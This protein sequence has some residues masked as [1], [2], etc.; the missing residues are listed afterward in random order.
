MFVVPALAPGFIMR[1]NRRLA[2]TVQHAF[3]KAHALAYGEKREPWLEDEFVLPPVDGP[4]KAFS[5]KTVVK[6]LRS[7]AKR[8]VAYDVETDGRHPLL[9]D[10]R[11]VGFYD[12]KQGVT[13]P[14]LRRNGDREDRMVRDRKG[15]V[16]TEN[17]AV[18]VRYWSE[19][20]E[21]EIVEAMRELIGT[22]NK[23]RS[24][25]RV[26]TQNGQYDRMVLWNALGLRVPTGLTFD[27]IVA[28]HVICPYLPH[29]LGF[30]S[31]LYTN[32]PF[33]KS[34]DKGDSWASESDHELFLYCA[35]G[36]TRVVMADGS[37]RAIKDLVRQ[38]STEEVRVVNERGEISTSPIYAWHQVRV[39][40]QTWRLIRNEATTHRGLVLT[41]DHKVLIKNR[42]K[43]R[44]D[45]VKVGDL[46]LL[47]ERRFSLRQQSLL[48]GTLLG[49]SVL[50]VSPAFRGEP[51]KA[52]AA[53]VDGGQVHEAY[54]REKVRAL[55]GIFALGRKRRTPHQDFHPFSSRQ[56]VQLKEW[57]SVWRD[58]SGRRRIGRELLDVLAKDPAGL[59]WWF[60]DDG[61][62]QKVRQGTDTICL[63]LLRYPEEDRE[64][65]RAWFEE[66]FGRV[67][68]YQG[69]LRFSVPAT[70]RFTSV[71]GPFL[72]PSVRYKLPG[73]EELPYV[74]EPAEPTHEPVAVRV[75]SNEEYIPARTTRSQQLMAETRFCISTR[76]GNFFTSD[77]LIKNCLRDVKTTWLIAEKMQ[78]E[79]R[80]VYPTAPQVFEQDTWQEQACEDWKQ[81]GFQLDRSALAFFRQHYRTVR[82]RALKAMKELVKNTLS[83][84]GFAED[85]AHAE[86]QKLLDKLV[87][88]TDDDADE[89]SSVAENFNPGSLIELRMMLKGL[90]IPLTE[91]TATG[92]LSTAKELLTGAR[93]EL[94]QQ[95]AAADDPRVAFLDYLFAWRE[96]AKVDGTYLYPDVQ[97]DG[98]V[99]STF[100]VHVV[101]TGRLCIAEWTQVRTLEKGW[102]RV[103][104]VTP[105]QHVWTH[106]QR[107]RPVTA[108]HRNGERETVDL[109]LQ[110]GEVVTATTDHRFW[111]PTGWVTAGELLE[112]LK[113]MARGEI[114]P[115]SSGRL[116][117][118]PQ[119]ALSSL[120][121]NNAEDYSSDRARRPARGDDERGHP[122]VG[123]TSILGVQDWQQESHEGE[124]HYA[125]SSLA[126]SLRGPEGVF[127]DSLAG[128][129]ALR[130]SCCDDG[131]SGGDQTSTE[132]VRSSH[133]REQ[134]QQRPRQPRFGDRSRSQGNP[135][136]RGEG[137]DWCTVEAV[138]PRGRCS[139]VDL[140][141]AED[142][143]FEVEG[144][145]FSHNSSSKPNKQNE[146]P[147]I[148]G[149]Y[150]ARPGHVLISMDWDAGEMRLG[151]F[152]S[153][154]KRYIEVFRQYDAK[155][156]P[157]PHIANMASIFG[158]PATKAAAEANPGMY[159]AAK[160]F[161]YAVAY[162]AGEDTVF[163]QVREEMPDMSWD[164]FKLAYANY[165]K[166]YPEFFA[167]LAS[168]VRSGSR[169]GY[170]DSPLMQ[171]RMFFFEPSWDGM[172]PEATQMQNSP[173]QSG[174]AD[175]VGQANR[176]IN[177]RV[178]PKWRE[179]L[180]KGEVILQLAQVHDELVYE[181]PERLAEELQAEI[182]SV[183][184][185]KPYKLVV[186]NRG[187]VSKA[188]V[189][190][191]MPVEAHF[192]RRWKPVK[193]RCGSEEM[194]L[195]EANEAGDRPRLKKPVRL[196]KRCKEA[197][198]VELET[199]SSTVWVGECEACGSTKRIE[200][201]A[202]LAA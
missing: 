191:N 79:V 122:R 163:A 193:S 11:C 175:V 153:G 192:A 82:D 83:T 184:Q 43:V 181:V 12:G 129:A 177:E 103:D 137:F 41:P 63:S 143:S 109:E 34:T 148:R 117:P 77:G 86:L 35:R 121:R 71:V 3:S 28:H 176:R 48:A 44:A 141:V 161:A 88:K 24:A 154:D 4:T 75:T 18:W 202:A 104:E 113:V 26:Y 17:R 70:R 90:G 135:L 81:A 72:H 200:V 125:S 62:R 124:N 87:K 110:N 49:D 133:R 64:T 96:A 196:L 112:R 138:V 111:S 10:L 116:V 58:D 152:M 1:Q 55:P 114:K 174:L 80:E 178:L 169:L 5:A 115:G 27:T 20:D 166:T 159:R 76:A 194:W 23:P 50:R 93:K 171:R 52:P 68:L 119:L 16:T 158:L 157:K 14:L 142:H 155:T 73:S 57:L 13:V 29:D 160:V 78:D 127:D 130:S 188:T 180:R 45:E 172:S 120:Y 136:P 105:G 85:D 151:A 164:A 84:R 150:V 6:L 15:E 65:A 94:L 123:A 40:G 60:G 38:K 146:P 199:G 7:M 53:S 37:T 89:E 165:K 128:Q 108:L 156:G 74:L 139:T 92:E 173:F 98:G 56:F 30:L 170:I 186:D 102:I 149:M 42:G 106:H 100:S 2:G 46:M 144:G 54:T 99:H 201:D 97:H 25:A 21:R 9:N 190:W 147:E 167:F 31:A 22:K 183:A 185:E 198:E 47:A 91:V 132:D 145:I 95:G 140:E 61:C 179:R 195:G 69:V 118:R 51:Q 33:Y 197:V 66:R 101:P 36:D 32:A 189:D 107:W 182:V 187:R 131:G 134:G 67:G 162:G 39:K 59:A 126:G 168:C 19:K 8:N